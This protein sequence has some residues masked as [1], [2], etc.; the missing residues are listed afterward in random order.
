MGSP[1]APQ[2]P[3]DEHQGAGDTE[4]RWTLAEAEMASSDHSTG[5]ACILNHVPC[6]FVGVGG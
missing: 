4:W 5:E 6:A 3:H 1:A 2:A